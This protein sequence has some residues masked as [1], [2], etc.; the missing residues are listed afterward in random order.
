MIF[1]ILSVNLI[2]KVYYFSSQPLND[3]NLFANSGWDG[4]WYIG[5]NRTWIVKIP[6]NKIKFDYDEAFIGVKIGR[7]KGDFI[8]GKPVKKQYETN[9]YIKLL[10]CKIQKEKIYKLCSTFDIPMESDF[11]YAIEETSDSKWFFTK[12]DKDFLE[13]DCI[14]TLIFINDEKFNGISSC[15]VLAGAWE[16]VKGSGFEAWIVEPAKGG[17]FEMEKM[18][19]RRIYSFVP[20]VCLK[21]VKYEESQLNFG[22]NFIE[23]ST[24]I[25]RVQLDVKGGIIEVWAEVATDN[26]TFG[27]VSRSVYAPPFDFSIRNDELPKGRFFLRFAFKD[28]YERVHYSNVFELKNSIIKNGRRGN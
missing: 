22:I 17:E 9:I 24:R 11:E 10:D 13:N 28:E 27:K 4:N 6:V 12:I 21:L 2:S 23:I 7:M 1:L 18:F 15:P 3:Y 25:T 5:Y 26:K 19:E 14:Y 20:A 16:K 8:P